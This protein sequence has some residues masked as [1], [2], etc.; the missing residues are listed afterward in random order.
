MK[1]LARFRTIV[2]VILAIL[3]AQP[4][5]ASSLN[6]LGYDDLGD[7]ISISGADNSIAGDLVIPE[8]IDGKPVTSIG[9]GA[10]YGSAKLK[11]V[12]L[13]SGLTKIE[14]SA[15]AYCRNLTRVNIPPGVTTIA[16]LAFNF[17]GNLSDLR[18]SSGVKV[19]GEGAFTRCASLEN[20]RIPGSVVEIGARA[21]Y[22]CSKLFNLDLPSSVTTLG[23]SAFSVCGF[24]HFLIPATVTSLGPSVFSGC[25][26]LKKVTISPGNLVNVPQWMF[27]DCALLENVK[28]PPTVTRIDSHAFANSGL[29]SVEFGPSV[30][31]IDAWAFSG[32]PDLRLV[33]CPPS[34]MEIGSHAFESCGN[35]AA[36]HFNGNAPKLGKSSFSSVSSGFKIFTGTKAKG[37]TIPKWQGYHTS[38]PAPEIAIYQNG[39]AAL[40]DGD[41]AVKFGSR[42][43]GDGEKVVRFEI[44]NVGNLKLTGLNAL[45]EGRNSGDFTVRNLSRSALAPGKSAILEI[46]YAPRH[47]GRRVARLHVMSNDADENPFDIEISGT[48]LELLD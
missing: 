43:V 24:T 17:C 48:G 14:S 18:I 21:F 16:P 30:R 34:V 32:C 40:K 11:S 9:I 36:V 13:P 42:I 25:R 41:A 33:I 37:F 2:P 46:S 45:I 23:E 31:L 28:L 12:S 1:H 7:S 6:G 35:L 39:G 44:Q 10:F 19:I 47:K 5:F 20:V 8:T 3:S 29:K 22:S 15:F 26:Q 4:L 38:F 27:A